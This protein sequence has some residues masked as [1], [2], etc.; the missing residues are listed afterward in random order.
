MLFARFFKASPTHHRAGLVAEYMALAWLMAKGYTPVAHRYKTKFGEIDLVMRKGKTLAFIEVKARNDRGVAAY[1]IHGKN[2]SRVMRAAQYFL[3]R[4]AHYDNMQVRF[5]A[6][7][8]AWY[9]RPHHIP[10]AFLAT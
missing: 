2:Q 7:L 4:H 8:I 5:D 9:K 1:A 6:V 10:H 3:T